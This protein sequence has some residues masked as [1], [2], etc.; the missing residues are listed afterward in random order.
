M[1]SLLV[2][3][4]A[5]VVLHMLRSFT[6]REIDFVHIHGIGVPGWLSGPSN[7]SW[8]DE[9]VSPSSEFPESYH[10]SVKLPCFVKPLFP[11][12]AS[13]LLSV[14]E[15]CDSH[16]DSELIGHPSL[17]GV[18]EDAIKINSAACLGQ[19]KG[20]GVFIKVSVKLVHVEGIDSL[21]GLVLDV[22]WDEGFFKGVTQFL[23]VFSESGMA[24]LASLRYQPLVKVPP[25]PLFN[26][27]RK[28]STEFFSS[29]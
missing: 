13:L 19:F 16:H 10:I 6:R 15:N 23:K 3:N 28:T 2:A 29:L 21:V 27:L 24:G 20:G 26:L 11:F 9:A 7:L 1:V 17:K 22:L 8:W 5:F 14:W 25:L 4:E 12:P 18:Y